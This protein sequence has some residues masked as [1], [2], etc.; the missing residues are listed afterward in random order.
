MEP[1]DCEGDLTK[2]RADDLRSLYWQLKEH[3]PETMMSMYKKH[4]SSEHFWRQ[5]ILNDVLEKQKEISELRFDSFASVLELGECV[6]EE[7]FDGLIEAVFPYYEDPSEIGREARHASGAPDVLVWNSEESFWFFAEVK[8]PNDGLRQSQ[9]DWIWT[10]W[11]LIR[12]KFV[13]IYL[14]VTC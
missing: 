3:G 10:N 11:N 9:K 2:E 13:L 8:G 7:E 5:V 14:N 4:F 12:G 1:E 6:A